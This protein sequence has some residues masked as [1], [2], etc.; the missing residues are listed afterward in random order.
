VE[1]RLYKCLIFGNLFFIHRKDNKEYDICVIVKRVN[2]GTDA[3]MLRKN[4]QFSEEQ[5]QSQ[6][7]FTTGDL[8]PV[9]TSWCQAPWD[10]RPEILFFQLEPKNLYLFSFY[11]I[12]IAQKTTP[13]KILLLF[14]IFVEHGNASTK[15]LPSNV[16]RGYKYTHTDWWER[17]MKYAV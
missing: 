12:W 3:E 6:S 1:R 2:N 9:S 14:C 17:F 16:M 4:K 5:S 15:P 10:S 7:Y 8:P 13:P 11:M